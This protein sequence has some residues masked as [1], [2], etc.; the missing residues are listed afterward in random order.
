VAN[1]NPPLFLRL[2]VICWV[3]ADA[4]EAVDGVLMV[5]AESVRLDESFKLLCTW[6]AECTVE[7]EGL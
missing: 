6:L 2:M 1:A 3:S 4:V 7:E 5:V